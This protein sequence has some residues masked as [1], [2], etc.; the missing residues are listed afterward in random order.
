MYRY[1]ERSA[2]ALSTAHPDLQAVFMKVLELYDHTII[3]GHR[4]Q[5]AQDTAFG[6]GFSRVEWPNS[7]HNAEP[8]LAVDAVPYPSGWKSKP[9]MR[10]FAGIVIGV[11]HAMGVTIRW[12]G[13][14]DGDKDFLDQE[15]N[16]LAH[17]ELVIEEAADDV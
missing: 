5:E 7:K 16:D 4:G 13:D 12:G 14:W 6:T 3:S 17:F 15:F 10:F 2:K 11:A 9:Q 8:S 1:S